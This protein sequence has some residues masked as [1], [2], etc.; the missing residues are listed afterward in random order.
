VNPQGEL[1]NRVVYISKCSGCRNLESVSVSPTPK[2]CVLVST[3]DENGDCMGQDS[4][5]AF[6]LNKSDILLR[7]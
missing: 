7:F 6:N 1:V 4:A 2:G 3:R 5:Y